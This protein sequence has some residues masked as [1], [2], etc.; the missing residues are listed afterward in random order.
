MTTMVRWAIFSIS[1]NLIILM[2]NEALKLVQSKQGC[3]PIIPMYIIH[4]FM[5]LSI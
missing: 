4:I 3:G 5:D 1:L 2:I